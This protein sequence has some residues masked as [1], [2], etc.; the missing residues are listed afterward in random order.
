[1]ERSIMKKLIGIALL[2]AFSLPAFAQDFVTSPS[3]EQRQ[4][5]QQR[6]IDQGVRAGWITPQEAA[7][8]E[9]GQERVRQMERDALANGRFTPYE[10]AEIQDELDRQSRR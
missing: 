10:R 5:N 8:L 6:R 3:I 2:S 7:R 4:V 9:R 1:M